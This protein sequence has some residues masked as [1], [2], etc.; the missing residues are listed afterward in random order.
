MDID[1]YIIDSNIFYRGIP[2][3]SGSNSLYYITTEILNEIQHLKRN[4]DGINTLLMI[5]KVIIRDPSTLTIDNVKQKGRKLGQ[6]GLSK[7]DLSLIALGVEL[8]YPI[9]SSDFSLINVAKFFLIKTII[10]GKNLF[11][12]VYSKKYCSICKKT[13]NVK[14]SFCEMCGNKLILKKIESI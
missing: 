7:A 12:K 11:V 6:F 2:F 13:F 4:I 9:I 1:K 3:Q 14:K 5:G 8:G 10:P